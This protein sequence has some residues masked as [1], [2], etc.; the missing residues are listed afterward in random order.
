MDLDERVAG[1]IVDRD[2]QVVVAG[3][4]SLRSLGLAALAELAPATTGADPSELLHVDVQ[5]LPGAFA[6]VADRDRRRTVQVRQARQ[7][8]ATQDRV[9]RGTRMPELGPQAMRSDLQATTSSAD[10]VDLTL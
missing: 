8:A 1:V 2:V 6:L 7:A 9:D 4:P 3:A 10:P 5:E